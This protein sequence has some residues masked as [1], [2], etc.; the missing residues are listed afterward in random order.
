MATQFDQQQSA[1]SKVEEHIAKDNASCS[2][3]YQNIF[4]MELLPTKLT[5][6]PQQHNEK[7]A[8]HHHIFKSNAW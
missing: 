8:L 4:I 7:T 3:F 2:Y 6:S 1:A 5:I